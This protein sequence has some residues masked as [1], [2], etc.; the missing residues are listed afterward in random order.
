MIIVL[1]LITDK[2]DQIYIAIVHRTVVPTAN[3]WIIW[4]HPK[5]FQVH[6]KILVFG[7]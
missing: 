6:N 5:G 3:L 1:Q 4:I 7:L 2:S